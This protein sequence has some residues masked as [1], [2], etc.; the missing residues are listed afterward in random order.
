[1]NEQENKETKSLVHF[2]SIVHKDRGQAFQKTSLLCLNKQFVLLK[3]LEK[4]AC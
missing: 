4:Q 1:M 3:D 2:V